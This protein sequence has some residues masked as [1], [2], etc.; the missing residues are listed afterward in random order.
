MNKK[1]S[2]ATATDEQA[3][4]NTPKATSGT[5]PNKNRIVAFTWLATRRPQ[6]DAQLF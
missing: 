6:S 3:S 5:A 4:I 2:L 1:R